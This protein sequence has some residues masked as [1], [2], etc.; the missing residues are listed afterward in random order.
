MEEP[1]PAEPELPVSVKAAS[2]SPLAQEVVDT[3]IQHAAP[4]N[5][6]AAMGKSIEEASST[7][8]SCAKPEKTISPQPTRVLIPISAG[9][10]VVEP[11]NESQDNDT[12]MLL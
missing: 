8:A 10:S 11:K 3:V 5:E 2:S 7:P 6:N 1:A 9:T 4:S 12:E